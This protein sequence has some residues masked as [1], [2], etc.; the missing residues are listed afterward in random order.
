M[1][2]IILGIVIGILLVALFTAPSSTTHDTAF[3]EELK[4]QNALVGALAS[5]VKPKLDYQNRYLYSVSQINNK[6]F[7]VGL[8]GKVFVVMDIKEEFSKK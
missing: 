3:Q 7:G 2:K 8:F 1:K 6:T 5:F 4:S